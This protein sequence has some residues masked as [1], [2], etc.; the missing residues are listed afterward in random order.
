[1]ATATLGNAYTALVSLL[2]SKLASSC[3]EGRWE[4]G[5]WEKENGGSKRSR[6]ARTASQV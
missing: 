1:M 5:Y 6:E 4:S 3:W 2:C